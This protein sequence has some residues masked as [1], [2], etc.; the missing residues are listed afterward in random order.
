MIYMIIR[1]TQI[2]A[3]LVTGVCK[4]GNAKIGG[5]PEW[6]TGMS[7]HEWVNMTGVSQS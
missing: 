2:S 6:T 5:S 7:L 4:E 3:I 1:P